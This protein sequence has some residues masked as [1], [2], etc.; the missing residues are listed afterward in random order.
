MI[1]PQTMAAMQT[2]AASAFDAAATLTRNS[3]TPDAYG[4]QAESWAVVWTGNVALA[5]PTGGQMQ[6]YAN[7]VG[8]LV[9]WL[10][11]LPFGTTVYRGDKVTLSTGDVL[12]VQV[13]L[14][15]HSY[16]TTQ[17]V[18]ATEVR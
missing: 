17:M 9:T 15:P 18:L 12:L 11:K 6:A 7:V 5:K 10:V 14:T 8:D 2:L 16:G 3:P 4:S 13:V 1:N